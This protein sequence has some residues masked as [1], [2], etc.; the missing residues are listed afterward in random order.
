[1]K[2]VKAATPEL[3]T[4]PNIELLEVGED[5]ETM[6]GVFSFTPEDLVSAIQAVDDPG[7]RSPVVKLGHVDPRF[8]GQ[9]TL[10][11]VE[12]LRLENNGQTLVGD[13]VGVPVWLAQVMYSAYPRRSIEGAFGYRSKTGNEWDFVLTGVAL[14]GDAY[15]AI[16]TLEDVQALWGGT[17]PTLHPVEEVE[18]VAA[19]GAFFR[20]R[21]MDDMPNWL[22]KRGGEVAAAGV[23]AA[24]PLDS[25]RRA[26]YESLDASQMWWWIREVRVNPLELIVDDDEGGL[27]RVPVTVSG[28]DEI[29]FGDP[30]SVKVE[31]VEAATEAGQLVAASYQ[32]P[33]DT[34]R[35]VRAHGDEPH[36]DLTTD[37]SE[38]DTQKEGDVQLTDEALRR[39]GLEPGASEEDI[40]AAILQLNA[41]QDEGGTDGNED[42][43]PETPSDDPA[44][45]PATAPEEEAP[46]G[47]ESEGTTP[48]SSTAQIPE[49]MTLIDE[50]TLSE[51]RQG[52]AAARQLQ[53]RESERE[54]NA[55]LD[56]AVRAGKFPRSRRG[57]Y[58]KLWA[59]DAD[60]TRQLID[61]LAEGVVPVDETGSPGGEADP[62]VQAAY[63]DSWKKSVAAAQRGVSSRVKVVGD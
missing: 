42:S 41:Q 18:E 1:M 48:E 52:V 23:Q 3:V 59:A 15:P 24:L 30:V 39:L 35:Q 63:P 14:L 32:A 54:R 58:E 19:A 5:W 40:N 2:I 25:V 8:D 10:G 62:A 11:R 55:F 16:N 29:T 47:T 28:N 49:G 34:G 53:D 61:S 43:Q 56:Q 44:A 17:P 57:H 22:K 38:E 6:T 37:E 46:E 21:R 60:G 7:I 51:L 20:A 26:Y 27:Y 4:V 50:A 33:A 9:P 36:D 31:Y 45:Q 12:N 13:L